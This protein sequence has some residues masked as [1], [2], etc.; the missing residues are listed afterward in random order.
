MSQNVTHWA[1]NISV[2]MTERNEVTVYVNKATLYNPMDDTA[3]VDLT[4]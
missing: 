4:L 1:V 3:K 2:S